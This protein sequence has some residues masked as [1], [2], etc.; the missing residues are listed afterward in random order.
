MKKIFTKKYATQQGWMLL[1]TV[2]ILALSIVAT[3]LIPNNPLAQ[4]FGQLWQARKIIAAFVLAFLMFDLCAIIA[5]L[6]YLNGVL[7]MRPMLHR[8]VYMLFGWLP[9]VKMIDPKELDQE[10]VKLRKELKEQIQEKKEQLEEL[11]KDSQEYK[12]AKAEIG[13]LIKQ[14]KSMDLRKQTVVE[15]KPAQ[16]P[17]DFPVAKKVILVIVDVIWYI[18]CVIA[19]L[20]CAIGIPVAS[21]LLV[22]LLTNLIFVVTAGN[23]IF[24]VVT[25]LVLAL[26]L[27]VDVAYPIAFVVI[28]LIARAAKKKPQLPEAEEEVVEETEEAEEETEWIDTVGQILDEVEKEN[29]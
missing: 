19:Y 28:E 21:P 14:V 20:V 12:E 1:L 9:F 23:W 27:L 16:L 18:L 17:P 2:V 29:Q 3:S 11:D 7:W 25:L 13:Q 22:M 24:Y 15:N 26:V 6:V 8:A 10:K 5:A 4:Q